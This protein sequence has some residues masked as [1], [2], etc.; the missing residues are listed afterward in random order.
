[1]SS[2]PKEASDFSGWVPV[3]AVVAEGTPGVVWMDLRGIE[4]R[5]P[6][7]HQT[8]T[9]VRTD[10]DRHEKFSAYDSLLQF[11]KAVESIPPTGFIFHSSRCGSTVVANALKSLDRT[12]VVSEP[13]AVDK[14]VGRLATDTGES[15]QRTL[16]YSL[17]L[18]G[19]VSALGQPRRG[20]ENNFF[21]KFS[22][23]SVLQIDQI[24]RIWPDVPWLFLYRD[25]VAVIVSNLANPPEW[26][27]TTNQMERAV[28]TGASEGELDDMSQAEYCART[29]GRLYFAAAAAAASDTRAK[30]VNHNELSH[31]KMTEILSFFGLT[32]SSAE[33]LAIEAGMGHHAKDRAAR[34]YRDDSAAKQE[35]ASAEVREM[36]SRWVAGSYSEL[37][38]LRQ[39]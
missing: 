15:D 3:D 39:R 17:F 2:L 27:Q 28:L 11:E 37:E 26:L 14:L 21:L 7:F 33:S 29:L 30:L 36:A 10:A 6:F 8:I 22:N 38:R 31:A 1:M 25:P 19:A 24:R 32:T 16:M 12:V 4:F 23:L 18:R 9:R 13:Q 35:S 20:D 34:R 5:E